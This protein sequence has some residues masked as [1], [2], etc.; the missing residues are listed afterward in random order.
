MR[1]MIR[2]IVWFLFA[3]VSCSGYAQLH[4]PESRMDFIQADIQRIDRLDGKEDR[5]VETGDSARNMLAHHAF[6]ILPDTIDSYIKR[7]F[8][9]PDRAYYRDY[10]FR[11]LRRVHSRN[12]RAAKAFDGLFTHI[13]RELRAV[14]EKNLYPVLIENVPLSI[15]TMALYKKEPVTDSFLCY[16]A[17]I[18]PD[19]IFLNVEEFQK[20]PY[21]AHVVEYAARYAPQMAKKYFLKDDPI[22]NILQESTDPAIQILLQIT[23]DIGKKSN[24]YVLLDDIV[25][26]NLTIPQADS[27]GK[28]NYA[29]LTTLM[30]IRRQKHPL[31][32]YSLEQEL[33]VQALKYVRKV[34]D[35]HNEKDEVRFQSVS[36]FSADQLYTL[37]VY[38]EEEIF[39]STFNGIYKRFTAKLGKEDGFKFIQSMGENRFRTFIK[40]CAAY[41][42]LDQFL[43]TM[44]PEE[45][46]ILL[47]KFAAGLDHEG[48]DISQAVEVADAYTSIHDTTIQS[49]LQGT[50]AM[51][52]ERVTAEHNK[53]GM[54]IY[55][56]LSNLFSNSTL[57]KAA[58][59]ANISGKYKLPPIDILPSARLFE[60]NK[61]C[62]WHMY[63]YDDEDGGES[64]RAFLNTF[65]DP[66]AWTIDEHSPLYVR[67]SSKGGKPV[68]IFANRPKEEYNGQ[69][70][71]EHYFDSAAIT[72]DVL[73]HRGHSY[74]AYKTIEKTKA[75]T[76]IFVLGS[77]GGYHNLTNIIDRAPDVSIISS[78]QI[79]VYAVNN[80]ILKELADNIRSGKDIDW[81]LLWSRVD[82]R[83]KGN[84][85][86]AKFLDYVPPHK[87]LGAIFIRAYNNLI[88]SN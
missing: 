26:G 87:N 65:R 42:N 44:T 45:R 1:G 80:P 61:A 75:D 58:W 70:Y 11:S 68:E 49:I 33:E 25:K 59:Y 67:I 37:I 32:E 30:D 14:K 27:I 64:F 7:N 34:N 4:P 72:P 5:K 39:T 36:R 24:S 62:I 23:H 48:T 82:A 31:A 21:A 71:L 66:A 53:K 38:S 83:L 57:F 19:W 10:L 86:Y 54:A 43:K 79:G 18:N 74:Y 63:F 12:Y 77:C 17:R 3:L 35:L 46:N 28:D 69:A 52:L 6:F 16:A 13:Y 47:V 9:E 78:K 81:Q 84:A 56:L 88:E 40:Q 85:Q 41:G 73:I 2:H 60:S 20:Q 22:Q 8:A 50:I 55:G 29:C 15:Q 51:E 76:K